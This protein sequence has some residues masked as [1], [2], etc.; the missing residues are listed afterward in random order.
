MKL[1]IS[2]G[3]IMLICLLYK[4]LEWLYNRYKE[5]LNNIDDH[6]ITTRLELTKKINELERKNNMNEQM[7]N[8]LWEKVA[9][10]KLKEQNK[11]KGEKK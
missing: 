6:T 9:K 10:E 2:L 5:D 1:I 4:L 3:I 7:I 11:K 8:W